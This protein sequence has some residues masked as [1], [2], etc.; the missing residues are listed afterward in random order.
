MIF[1]EK[2][3]TIN[4]NQCK[5]DSPVVLYR[6]DYN[7]EVRFSIVSSPYKY[8]NKQETNV[9]E[10]TEASYGQLVIKTP[11]DKAPI[12]S[13][14]TATKRGAITF[15][16]TTEMIDEITEVGNYTFQIRLLDENKESRATIP[17]VV[18]GIEIREPIATE[19]VSTTNE[20]GAATV[21]YALTTTGTPEDAFDSQG[22]YNKTAWVSGDRITAAKLNKIEAGIEGVN[23][24]VASG[25]T[26]GGSNI[27]DT[28]ASTT[29]TYSSNKIENIKEDLSSQ[30]KEIVNVSDLAQEGNNVYIKDSNGNKVG[31]GITIQTSTTSSGDSTTSNYDVE[32]PL[33]F[34]PSKDTDVKLTF[35]PGEVKKY[36]CEINSIDTSDWTDE[37]YSGDNHSIENVQE[38]G[39]N[40]LKATFSDAEGYHVMKIQGTNKF[41][42]THK[43]LIYLKVKIGSKLAGTEKP[44]FISGMTSFPESWNSEN[45]AA[46]N[47]D[48]SYQINRTNTTTFQEL[49][50]IGTI[51]DYNKNTC[52]LRIF[53]DGIIYVAKAYYID[54]TLNEL[55]TK[56]WNELK[57]MC[58]DGSFDANGG[59]TALFS[60]TIVNDTENT[61][62]EAFESGE[63]VQYVTVQGGKTLSVVKN[64]DYPLAN[65]IAQIKDTDSTGIELEDYQYVLNT[66][67]KGKKA[68]FEGDSITDSDFATEYNGKSW[69]DYLKIKLKLGDTIN[70]S[71]GGSTISTNNTATLN[72]SVVTRISET[73]YPV[74]VKLFIIFAG[75]NDWNNN[76]ALGDVDSTDSS[77]ILG[78]LNNCID[79]AQTKC[80]DATIVVIAPMHRS[81]MRT[82]ER[83]AG[84]L[85]AVAE[86]YKKVCRNWGVNFFDSL[87]NFGMNAYNSTIAAKYYIE[88]DGQL[89]P[90]PAGHK[91]IAVRMAGYISTL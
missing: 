18:N 82:V 9:I 28:A 26:S 20:V 88:T 46:K 39:L 6:G 25:G 59:G 83:T 60:A 21:G 48:P 63:N 2:K 4:N 27:N 62:I 13:E 7:V 74:D 69:A 33:P 71:V 76:V 50:A 14:I 78:A 89:H 3:I 42:S 36:N 22:N 61:N 5:I 58:Q 15:T 37:T 70:N 86:G 65:V 67:F 87:E 77:T 84:K 81:G 11:G 24:K 29:T 68:V 51:P 80:P 38:D 31:N 34:T 10:Q 23:Q 85:E 57:T 43:Y 49:M 47:I 17:E 45:I 40:C 90:N 16:I 53:N 1:T 91:R 79:N 32:I 75:T 54:L 64:G 56:T 66:R 55:E 12:F 52:N 73:N 35:S 19:D 41:D 30:I 44:D 72:G 8:S